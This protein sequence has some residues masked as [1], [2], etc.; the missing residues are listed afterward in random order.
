MERMREEIDRMLGS[1]GPAGW[2]FPFSRVSFLPGR[3]ARAYPLVNICE[4]RD[5]YYIDALAPGIDHKSIDVSMTGN[6]LT[7]T[8]EKQALPEKVSAESIHRNERS[9]GR[10]LRTVTFGGDVEADKISAAYKNGLLRIT[11]PKA[12]A[13]KPRQIEVSVS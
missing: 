7:I 2:G 12:E 9:A 4:D 10:F 6:Q 1:R 11:L 8:G 5:H 13:A 3:A